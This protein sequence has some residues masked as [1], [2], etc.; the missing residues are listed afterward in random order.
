M[1]ALLNRHLEQYRSDKEASDALLSVGQAPVE[2]DADRP[3]LAAWTSVAR[4]LL[5]LHET[6][7]R[8]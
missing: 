1:L 6:I 2:K 7:T 8:E 3:A 5:N 4:I